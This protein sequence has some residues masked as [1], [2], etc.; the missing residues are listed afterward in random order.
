MRQIA[1]LAAYMRLP[2]GIENLD[3]EFAA[4]LVL[5]AHV[6]GQTPELVVEARCGIG[7]EAFELVPDVAGTDATI[8]A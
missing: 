2:V 8:I 7:D 6:F 3:P 4:L 5:P 1:K